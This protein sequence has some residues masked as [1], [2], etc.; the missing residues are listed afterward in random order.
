MT[1][2]EGTLLSLLHLAVAEAGSQ[3]TAA[4][5]LRVSA[6]YLGDLLHGRR[7]LVGKIVTALGY[8][9]VVMFE[10]IQKKVAHG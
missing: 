8:R 4:K 10:P 1:I 6:Q 5:R 2:D 7:P 9:R 3:K